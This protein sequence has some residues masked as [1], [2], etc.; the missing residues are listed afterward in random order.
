[1]AL[2]AL[3]GAYAL[4]YVFLLITSFKPAADVLQIPPTFLPEQIS[5]E[6]YRA[7]FANPSVPGAFFN[8]I[9]VA[10]L[11]TVLALILAV[12][13]AYGASFFRTPF[14][15]LVPALRADH[16]HGALGLA[17]RAAVHPAED[18][19]ACSTPS[20]AWCWRTRR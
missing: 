7:I 3:V 12:P 20:L 19:S 6:N 4:P 8:S 2:I 5:L 17:R 10:S 13:A 14:S 16:P 9:V 11:S 1:M 15:T 18:A